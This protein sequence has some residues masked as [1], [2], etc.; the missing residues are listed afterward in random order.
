[1]DK[2]A[3]IKIRGVLVGDSYDK[4]VSVLSEGGSNHLGIPGANGSVEEISIDNGELLGTMFE[5]IEISFLNG[6]AS[7]VRTYRKFGS[8]VS[9]DSLYNSL[10][11][12]LFKIYGRADLETSNK[13]LQN[14]SFCFYSDAFTS[15][16]VERSVYNEKTHSA[17]VYIEVFD[18]IS[19]IKK[20]DNLEIYKILRDKLF[21]YRDDNI[22][23]N[24]KVVPN[25]FHSIKFNHVLI[26]IF[27]A[28]SFLL[29][30]N[31]RY[32]Y[33]TEGCVLDKW[34]GKIYEIDSWI[35]DN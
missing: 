16:R 4:C 1:M 2:Y 15:V 18:N 29:V 12:H 33:P 22:I 3:L 8:N 10:N 13:L 26:C 27:L 24:N 34:T 31:G 28:I 35:V 17:S 9:A 14:G 5:T 25:N 20:M 19:K 7:T 6:F 11:K 21:K 30:L 23:K 32:S